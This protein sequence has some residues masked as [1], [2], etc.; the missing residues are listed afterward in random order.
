M[1]QKKEMQER[2]LRYFDFG[3]GQELAK[4]KVKCLSE[5][6]KFLGLPIGEN[7][8][9]I[10][11]HIAEFNALVILSDMHIIKT[12]RESIIFIKEK[13][14]EYADVQKVDKN[15]F[16]TQ[17]IEHLSQTCGS[18]G[19]ATAQL[20]KLGSN[21]KE[22]GCP[23][24]EHLVGAVFGS[25]KLQKLYSMSMMGAIDKIISNINIIKGA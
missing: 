1:H 11:E 9:K 4:E 10:N 16:Q 7:I 12:I 3:N 22:L 24:G 19:E 5:D 17:Y 2:L 15:T 25:N 14:E 20:K 18:K 13:N 6:M 23:L 8:E 21:M